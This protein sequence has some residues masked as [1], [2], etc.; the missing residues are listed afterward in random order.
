MD[1]KAPM[2][3]RKQHWRPVRS[4]T[5]RGNVPVPLGHFTFWGGAPE[6]ECEVKGGA[7]EGE[8][9]LVWSGARAAPRSGDFELGRDESVGGMSLLEPPLVYI[10]IAFR[11]CRSVLN[12]VRYARR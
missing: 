11:S 9:R 1:R 3:V 10:C 5:C 12:R 4:A 8:C 2:R 7:L 6:G